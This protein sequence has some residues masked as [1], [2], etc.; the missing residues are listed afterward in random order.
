[1]LFSL[2]MYS[3]LIGKIAVNAKVTVEFCNLD[4]S[5]KNIISKNHAKCVF[6]YFS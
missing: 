6:F 2:H 5:E 4:N 1:M 3:E